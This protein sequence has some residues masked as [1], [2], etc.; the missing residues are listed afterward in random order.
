[1]ANTLPPVI[2][3]VTG[4][5][6]E[7]KA[8]VV[9][10]D[11]PKALHSGSDFTVYEAWIADHFPHDNASTADLAKD[12]SHGD[13]FKTLSQANGAI[14]RAV[15][16]AP[17]TITSMHRTQSL[18]FG[19]VV[20][21]EVYLEVDDGVEQLIKQGEVVVQRGTM[22]R[23]TNKMDTW[24]RMYFVLLGA[25]DL[26]IDGVKYGSAGFHGQN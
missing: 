19:I 16:I 21:G 9:K 26:Y 1:M 15:D 22:H 18:D 20:M 3:Y 8:I 23:W 17:N 2:R 24:V 14:C 6:P 12:F 11:A 10:Q 25:Q 4:H 7:G 5:T 13:T